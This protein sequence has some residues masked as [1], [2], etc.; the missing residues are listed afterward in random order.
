MMNARFAS[1]FIFLMAVSAF[2]P[3]AAFGDYSTWTDQT[4]AGSHAWY[5]ITSSSDGTKLAAVD[6]TPRRHLNLHRL[7]RPRDRQTTAGSRS[8]E[9]ITSS[10]DGTKIAAAV[11]GGGDTE[12]RAIR[13]ACLRT[14]R[15]PTRGG[16]TL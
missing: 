1:L 5:A 4:L 8:W 15:M 10:A 7:R 14:K 11:W 9:T 16:A 13:Y 12:D 6:A 2:I 3:S